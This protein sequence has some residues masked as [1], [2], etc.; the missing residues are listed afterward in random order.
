V[1]SLTVYHRHVQNRHV[2]FRHFRDR[3]LKPRANQPT[4]D[5]S[6]SNVRSVVTLP[7][8]SGAKGLVAFLLVP[9]DTRSQHLDRTVSRLLAICSSRSRTEDMST[10]CSCWDPEADTLEDSWRYD[11]EETGGSIIGPDSHCRYCFGTGWVSS[12]IEV[13]FGSHCFRVKPSLAPSDPNP[14]TWEDVVCHR[15]RG[16][17]TDPLAEDD[18]DEPD[19]ESE[20]SEEAEP[21][22]TTIC[23]CSSCGGKGVVL[24]NPEWGM[25]RVEDVLGMSPPPVPD[26]FIK[27]N[28]Y[29]RSSVRLPGNR[30]IVTKADWMAEWLRTLRN[31]TNEK[32]VVCDLTTIAP[33]RQIRS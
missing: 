29:W 6:F 20:S 19:C 9:E 5:R 1:E 21:Q 15:C 13:D 23:K 16:T 8:S 7:A 28:G 17:G 32:L 4:P 2:R 25:S 22:P 30:R 26:V 33:A 31:S 3:H 14:T 11:V 18:E 12:Y 27:S 10:H 24:Q